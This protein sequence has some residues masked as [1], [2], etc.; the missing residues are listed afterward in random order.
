MVP[1]CW[2]FI[3]NGGAG[4]QWTIC[5][6]VCFITRDCI[7]KHQNIYIHYVSWCND[8]SLWQKRHV[9]N[10]RDIKKLH[11]I[12]AQTQCHRHA[13]CASCCSAWRTRLVP[14]DVTPLGAV[15]S[16]G[17]P[18]MSSRWWGNID[19]QTGEA[20]EKQ[21]WT[22]PYRTILIPELVPWAEGPV[23]SDKLAI[24]REFVVYIVLCAYI[25]FIIMY[26][27][28]ANICQLVVSVVASPFKMDQLGSTERVFSGE[29]HFGNDCESSLPLLH[30]SL[31]HP[32]NEYMI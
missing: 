6:N 8:V 1:D 13:T 4:L 10:L 17:N 16:P 12:Q 22:V 3:H 15:S 32:Q 31:P 20:W 28:F 21:F 5:R 2:W 25:I 11:P 7:I 9:L 23:Q 29:R 30:R 27:L 26:L 19:R 24:T 18:H 14:R